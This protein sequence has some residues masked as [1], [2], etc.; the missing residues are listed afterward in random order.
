MDDSSGLLPVARILHALFID[1]M[2]ITEIYHTRHA[3]W[4]DFYMTVGKYARAKRLKTSGPMV[5]RYH[6]S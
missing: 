6:L 1:L 5:P 2:W 4:M 3:L